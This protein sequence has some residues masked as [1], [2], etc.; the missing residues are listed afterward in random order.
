M[1]SQVM[2]TVFPNLPKHFCRRAIGVI[3]LYAFLLQSFLALTM[4][5]QA[6]AAGTLSHGGT[7]FVLCLTDDN[8]GEDTDVNGAPA[9]PVTHC[10]VCTISS[11]A[12]GLVPEPA[13]LPTQ[14][15][16]IA[17]RT[18]FV[19]AKACIS[20]HEARSGLTR[21]PPQNV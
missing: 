11:S 6:A 12:G 5:T 10:P 3:A 8:G 7:A 21:A 20:F 2:A 16:Y 18:P 15:S 14:V 13:V 4:V 1:T 19:T 17:Q 9:K